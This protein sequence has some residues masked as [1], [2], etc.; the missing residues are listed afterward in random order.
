MIQTTTTLS[1][2]NWEISPL[3]ISLYISLGRLSTCLSAK[4]HS[5]LN[6]RCNKNANM[7]EKNSSALKSDELSV[8]RENINLESNVKLCCKFLHW[9]LFI[10]HTSDFCRSSI[11]LKIWMSEIWFFV[12]LGNIYFNF[13]SQKNERN[14]LFFLPRAIRKYLKFESFRERCFIISNSMQVPL[15]LGHH[16]FTKD[17]WG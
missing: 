7:F 5:S 2:W 17:K 10:E 11:I 13:N 6:Y 16:E 9:L 12:C 8:D 14:R 3:I 1:I 4:R 15:R